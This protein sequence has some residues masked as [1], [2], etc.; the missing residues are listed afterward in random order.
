V[1]VNTALLL[2]RFS[3][4]SNDFLTGAPITLRALFPEKDG[5]FY[6]RVWDGQHCVGDA[7]QIAR[8]RAD[9][10]RGYRLGTV[11]LDRR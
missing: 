8:L 6:F 9:D 4:L 7:T 11:H 1:W 3:D 2:T 10:E 5:L